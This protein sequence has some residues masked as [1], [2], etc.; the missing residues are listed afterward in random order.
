MCNSV[1]AQSLGFTN[2]LSVRKVP[3]QTVPGRCLRPIEIEARAEDNRS[4]SNIGVWPPLIEI[5]GDQ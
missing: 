5:G 1:I 2:I 4:N 3:V